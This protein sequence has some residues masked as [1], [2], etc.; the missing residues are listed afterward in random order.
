MT[1][2]DDLEVSWDDLWTFSYGLSQYHGRDSWLVCEVALM[3]PSHL[4]LANTRWGTLKP[5]GHFGGELV[6]TT[7]QVGATFRSKPTISVIIL[8]LVI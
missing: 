5:Q 2:L 8:Y 7:L 1:T 6:H 4:A 3:S